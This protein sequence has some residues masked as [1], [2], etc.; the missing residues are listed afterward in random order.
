LN[1]DMNKMEMVIEFCYALGE[2]FWKE[3]P[4]DHHMRLSHGGFYNKAYEIE[5]FHQ[6]LEVKLHRVESRLDKR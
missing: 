6:T 3:H 1:Y 2:R 5:S 4:E